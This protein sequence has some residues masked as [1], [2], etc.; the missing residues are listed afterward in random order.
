MESLINQININF[1]IFIRDDGSSDKTKEILNS[2]SKYKNIEIEFG[3]NIG[4]IKSFFE[5]LEKSDGNADYYAF[6]DQDDF[7]E[8]EKLTRAVDMLNNQEDSLLPL[9]YCSKTKLVDENL[10]FIRYSNSLKR[11]LSIGNALVENIATGCTI[12]LNNSL[13]KEILKETV[14]KENIIMH[15][16]WVYLVALLKGKVIFDNDSYILYRQHQNNTVGVNLNPFKLFIKR[17]KRFLGN[18]KNHTFQI[19]CEELK[20]IYANEISKENLTKI[21]GFL[22]N[23]SKFNE[24]LNVLKERKFYRQSKIETVYIYI[25]ILMGR[26]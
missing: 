2:Y 20:R 10:N 11:K 18:K 7:W 24:R 23:R 19:Q 16:W 8:K 25:L 9:L 3:E 4:V 15:D 13:R 22:F 12:V 21:N 14:N 1:K 5:L 17:G 6:C 26:M